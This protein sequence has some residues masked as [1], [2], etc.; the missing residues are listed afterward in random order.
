MLDNTGSTQGSIYEIEM[1][2]SRFKSKIVNEKGTKGPQGVKGRQG[3]TPEDL[4]SFMET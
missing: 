2:R 3:L 1:K 4:R